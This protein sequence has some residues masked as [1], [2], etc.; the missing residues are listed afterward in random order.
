MLETLLITVSGTDRPGL[1][2]SFA[3]LMAEAGA[4]I[5]DIGQAVIHDSLTF[6]LM[7]RMERA[8]VP[9]LTD[10]LQE[11]AHSHF[12]KVRIKPV[13][14]DNYREWIEK[15]KQQ[16][17]IIT[18]LGSQ[19][20]AAHLASVTHEFAAYS[21]NIALM[22]RLSGR[23]L[24]ARADNPRMCIQFAVTGDNVDTGKL[25]H[26][27]LS[28][29]VEEDFD[30][31]I[32][33]DS[34]FRRNRR[35]VV[36]DM[37]STLIQIEVIDELARRAGVY[38]EVSSITAAAMRGEMDFP[39]SFRKRMALLKGLDASV[40]DDIADNLPLTPGASRLLSTLQSLG[41]KTGIVSGGFTHFALRLQ[42]DLGF[43]YVYA[44]ELEVVNG[45]L[46]GEIIGEII[47]GKRKAEILNEI[48]EKEHIALAQTIAVGDGANDLPMLSI[49]GIGVAFHAKP[50]VRQKAEHSISVMGLD[51]LL[52]LLG[53]RDRHIADSEANHSVDT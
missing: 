40:L 27:L 2:T 9:A 22:E 47:D 33:E 53:I 51:A 18:L 41:Y 43:N 10:A 46:T 4:T 37:D 50:L 31:A 11:E 38:N 20:T 29:A 45:R 12:V 52:Y 8:S 5:L 42:R 30:I 14:D 15:Q 48:A 19:I 16:R 25:R 32:Q 35:V 44:H 26:A 3:A 13:T 1:T 36:F 17:F 24:A 21:L 6:G 39:T 23:D 7:I 49:A 28:L 34:I